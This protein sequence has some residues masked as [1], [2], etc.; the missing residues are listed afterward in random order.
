MSPPNDENIR[1]R[2]AAM[3]TAELQAAI[4]VNR[5][6]YVPR[7]LELAAEELEKRADAPPPGPAP[8]SEQAVVEPVEGS[9]RRIRWWDIWLTLAAIAAIGNAVLALCTGKA[10]WVIFLRLAW[11]GLVVPIFWWRRSRKR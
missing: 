5:D 7:A 11:A 2:L 4:A 1:A 8:G 6:D 9:E 3:T 10:A